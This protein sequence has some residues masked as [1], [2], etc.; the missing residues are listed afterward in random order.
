MRMYE[1]VS[2]LFHSIYL[3][4]ASQINKFRALPSSFY[5]VIILSLLS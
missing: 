5:S 2:L 4:Y 1:G 3:T